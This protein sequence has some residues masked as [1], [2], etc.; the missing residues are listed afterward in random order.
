MFCD[1]CE[2]KQ[3]KH[4]GT[5]NFSFSFNSFHGKSSPAEGEK[6]CD[7]W[8]LICNTVFYASSWL[9]DYSYT[10]ANRHL[11]HFVFL[12]DHF[13]VLTLQSR[14]LSSLTCSKSAGICDS[15]CLCVFTGDCR[16]TLV[17]CRAEISQQIPWYL[18]KPLWS[19]TYIK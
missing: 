15:V 9:F 16:A 7:I 12:S 5:G 13:Y 18:L 11:R 19:V 14:S 10:G 4:F 8:R 3:K 17:P 1:F 2:N 6:Q